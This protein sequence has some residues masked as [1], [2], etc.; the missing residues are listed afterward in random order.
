M[1]PFRPLNRS[2]PFKHLLIMELV[3]KSMAFVFSILCAS[4][5]ACGQKVD[6]YAAKID[7]LIQTTKP[8]VF[9]GVIL[10]TQKGK[11]IYSKVHGYSNFEQKIPLK[12]NDNFRIQSNSKQ[13]TAV[14]ILKEVEKGRID[15]QSPVRKYLPEIK[16]SWADSVT[17]HQLLNFSSGIVS[18]DKP[19][20]FR[21]GTGFLYGVTTYTMLSQILEK[22]TGK[23]FTDLANQ[24]FTNLGMTN[25]FCFEK[26]KAK[27]NLI[28]GY[29]NAG[30]EYKVVEV[31]L[32]AQEWND[33]IP[34]GGMISNLVDLN[35][36]D[37]MLH[38]GKILKPKTYKLM[39]NYTIMA[40][41][42]SF[43]SEKI[44]Y[45]YGLRIHDKTPKYVG[46][47]GKGLG[48]ASIKM[49]F[50][51]KDLD[52]IVLENIYSSDASLHYYFEVKIREIVMNSSL[53]K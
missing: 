37:L 6:D 30:N 32:T 40:Q 8:R 4:H 31:S 45:G 14:L 24:L 50:P 42:E 3:V 20:V 26:V 38:K 44:G 9:N 39:T 21:P 27:D 48:F 10:I 11:T 7:S 22:V 16:Q 23:K 12:L 52:L 43:G 5:T 17:V 13:I 36:W 49:Y 2:L 41:H 47:S 46:H 34:A 25:S 51:E 53:L 18:I 19:L 28:N 35:K 1:A 33:F 15:L 29:T